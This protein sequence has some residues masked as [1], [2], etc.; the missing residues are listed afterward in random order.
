MLFYLWGI[1]T[2]FLSCRIPHNAI[3]AILPMRNWNPR[4][5]PTVRTCSSWCYSTYEELKPMGKVRVKAVRDAMLFYLWGIETGIIKTK[6]VNTIRM[7]FYLWGIETFVLVFVK[8]CPIKDA[9]LPMRN[10]NYI[11]WKEHSSKR[12]WCYSTYEELKP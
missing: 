8:P 2:D 7:L 1:E 6:M 12:P 9:I 4:P 11:F 3:D 10:W 5:C